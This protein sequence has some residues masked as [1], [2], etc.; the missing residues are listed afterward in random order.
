MLTK[1]NHSNKRH[2]GKLNKL[3]IYGIIGLI[4]FI[5]V[6]LI[7]NTSS[8]TIGV[9]QA[10]KIITKEQAKQ[11]AIS[12]LNKDLNM[13]DEGN[14]ISVTYNSRPDIYGYLSKEGLLKSYGNQYAEKFPYDVFKVKFK[15]P[16][17]VFKAITVDVH[18]ITGQVVGFEKMSI[19]N[20]ESKQ[21][22]LQ[23]D[24]AN[25]KFLLDREGPMTVAE[26]EIAALPYLKQ[27]GY[28]PNQLQLDNTSN[29]LGLRYQIK[30]FSI[31][32]AK[33]YIEL[34]FEYKKVISIETYF[35][36]P[37]S[38]IAYVNSQT[39]LA[40]WLT[41][42]G[43]VFLTFV[44]AILAIIYS[45]KTRIYTS[46]KR[47]IFLSASYF[48]FSVIGTLNMLPVL[49]QSITNHSV[50]I[51]SLIL[52]F[53]ITLIMSFSI[54]FSL[55]GGDG[56]YRAQGKILWKQ[57]DEANYGEHVLQAMKLGYA[58]A[59]IL[60]GVQ[61]ILYFIM[62]PIFGTWSTTDPT[63]S[64]Y[65]MVYPLLFPLLAWVAGI[66]EEAVYRLFGIPMLRKLFRSTLVASIVTTVIWALGHTLYPIYPIY[67]RPIELLFIGLIFSFI[68]L[69]HGYIAAMFAHVIFDSILMALSL[70]L[71]GGSVNWIAGIFYIALPAIVAYVV[72]R[73]NR[74]KVTS[75]SS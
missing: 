1:S 2:N 7:P 32:Q 14:Q 57:R 44:L 28:E 21:L 11:S 25:A 22:M 4:I 43:Y 3:W 13:K 17:S 23:I 42:A 59:L 56:L 50:L 27:F 70:I 46:F 47:G 5:F 35:S 51:K 26:K 45:A 54:Y 36:P 33:A 15:N 19:T 58:W 73:F 6:Q 66:G 34:Q 18:M 29:G 30:D 61:S 20:N 63:Q 16:N 38:H 9:N 52:Q 65:N 75:I 53:G 68:F 71:I 72:Y 67:T 41:Y 8:D 48:V 12:Y 74:A 69:K 62:E 55:V 39:S 24:P 60:L 37:A 64:P 31:G 40:S 10:S 49:E